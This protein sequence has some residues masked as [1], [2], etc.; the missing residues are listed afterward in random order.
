[1][2]QPGGIG[3]LEFKPLVGLVEN[4]ETMWVIICTEKKLK[5]NVELERNRLH[6]NVQLTNQ[7]QS[8]MRINS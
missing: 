6:C 1:M 4:K 8:F 5:M 7:Y 3:W 2:K